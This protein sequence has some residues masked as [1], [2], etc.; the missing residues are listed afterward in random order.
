MCGL[1][2][3]A[4][5]IRIE[6]ENALKKLKGLG[7]KRIVMLTG[8]NEG[9]AKAI[10]NEIYL[11]SFQSGL[12]PKDKIKQVQ[13][14]RK[15]YLTVAMV[16]DGVNDAPAMATAS[17]GI[18]MGAIGS[19]VAIETA[20]IALMSDDLMKIPWLIQHSRRTMRIIKENIIFALVTKAIFIVLAVLGVATLWMAITADMGAS[21]IVIFNG[22]RLLKKKGDTENGWMKS[23]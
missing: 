18:A 11:D 6:A 1:I 7:V 17:L 19:D 5:K 9:T 8:D 23:S 12:L 3:I 16:G 22:L 13:L 21:L 2:G 15:E 14:L 10:S 20:D 4:D